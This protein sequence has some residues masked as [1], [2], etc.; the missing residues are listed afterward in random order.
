MMGAIELQH[1]SARR[2]ERSKKG[3]PEEDETSR[4]RTIG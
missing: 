2:T 4:A 1:A 3:L